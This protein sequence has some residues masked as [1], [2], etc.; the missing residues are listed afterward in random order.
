MAQPVEQRNWKGTAAKLATYFDRFSNQAW[1]RTGASAARECM[2]LQDQI[3][4]DTADV[5][6]LLSTLEE[7]VADGG[8]AWDE[9]LVSVRMWA[10]EIAN[11]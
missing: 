5:R 8:S 3:Q 9:L 10:R 4:P 7:G 1:G 2:R 11:V 6:R